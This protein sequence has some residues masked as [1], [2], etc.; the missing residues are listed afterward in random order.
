M[1]QVIRE[2]GAIGTVDVTW[3][4]TSDPAHDLVDLNGTVTFVEGEK[5]KDILLKVVSDTVPELD[6]LF[7]MMLTSVSEVSIK[8][9]L[10]KIMIYL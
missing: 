9:L 3:E 8:L 7:Q 10:Y 4:M 6:E 2:G 1:Y 5:E